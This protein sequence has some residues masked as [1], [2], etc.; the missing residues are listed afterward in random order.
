MAV[1]NMY[2]QEVSLWVRFI[3]RQ[4]AKVSLAVARLG[5]PTRLARGFIGASFGVALSL[6]PLRVA[7]LAIVS[8]P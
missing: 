8:R 6:A 5:F 2:Y 3:S 7:P 4:L 1:T